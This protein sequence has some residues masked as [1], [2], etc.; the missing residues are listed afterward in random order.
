[1]KRRGKTGLIK[2]KL[3]KDFQKAQRNFDQGH[4]KTVQRSP[5]PW[6]QNIKKQ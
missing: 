1:M 4:F 2:K 5:A 3:L 6:E